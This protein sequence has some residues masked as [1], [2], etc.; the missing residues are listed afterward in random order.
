MKRPP[1]RTVCY[2]GRRAV[3]ATRHGKEQAI[4][5]TM[6]AALGL[7]VDVADID[8]DSLGTFTGEVERPGTMLDTAVAK[9]RLGMR[10]A[11]AR[12]GLASEGSYGP[13]PFAAFVPTGT[14]LLVLVDDDH[15]LV[16]HQAHVCERTNFDHTTAQ[17]AR[18]LAKYLERTGFPEHALV[19][20]PNEP[21]VRPWRLRLASRCPSAP[22]Y[23]AVRTHD[24]LERAV[25]HCARISKDGSARV[26]TDMR[27]HLNPTRMAEIARLAQRLADR[28]ATPCPQCAAPGFGTTEP[29]RGLPCAQCGTPT[30]LVRVEVRGCAACDYKEE[31]PRRDRMASASPTYCQWCNP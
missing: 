12:L 26:T 1:R 5:G 4:A 19:V 25:A 18:A 8:T 27:A 17:D 28:I 9:A 22:I 14:E 2:R 29:K 10:H 24:E 3:L 20:Q 13:H 16:I 11:G 23:K 6:L 15:G 31:V 7:A 21:A 30:D